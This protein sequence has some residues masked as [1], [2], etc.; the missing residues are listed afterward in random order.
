MKPLRAALC[1]IGLILLALPVV[2][3]DE[4]LFEDYFTHELANWNALTCCWKIIGYEDGKL[5]RQ[6]SGE[7]EGRLS[8]TRI[9][10]ADRKF[11]DGVVETKLRFAAYP[12]PRLTKAEVDRLGAGVIFSYQNESNFF[13]FRLSGPDHAVLGKI[14]RGRWVSIREV[15]TRRRL[16]PVVDT[17]ETAPWH[18]LK[19][20]INNSS[21]TC[22]IDNQPVLTAKVARL[23]PGQVGFT[24]FHSVADFAYLK[25]FP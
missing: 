6:K 19:V 25:V 5:L 18:L 15:V 21:I 23:Q 17:V 4:P 22:F 24:T 3:D 13:L 14:V 16:L 1:L 10:V 7:A 11:A 12:H 8:N 9:V 20:V 2:A